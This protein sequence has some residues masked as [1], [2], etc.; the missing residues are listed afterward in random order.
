MNDTNS[1]E[2]PSSPFA[3]F[4]LGGI[5][6]FALLLAVAGYGHPFPFMGR[7]YEGGAAQALVFADSL[8]SLYLFLGVVRRQ[9]LTV[10]LLIAYNMFDI[11]N[12]LVNLAQLPPAA[13]AKLAGA[14]VPRSELFA[15]TMT[16]VVLLLILNLVIFA[17]RRHFTNRSPYLF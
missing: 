3:L 11:V 4:A 9:R 14:P 12:A 5:Y 2:T 13:Y 17:N 16:A 15:D 7:F 8:I 10:W 1:D 6:L